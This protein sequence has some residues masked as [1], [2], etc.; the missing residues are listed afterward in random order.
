M[1][2]FTAEVRTLIYTTNPIENF[3]SQL[4]KV[5]KNRS[6][7]PSDTSLL[8]LL[9]LVTQDVTRKWTMRTKKWNKILAQLSIHFGERLT[10]YL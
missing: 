10:E 8:K 2:R 7:F 9:Y 3:H 4:Q 6:L 1:F 5:T